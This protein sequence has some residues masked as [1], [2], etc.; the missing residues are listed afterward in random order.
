MRTTIF[1][2]FP[3]VAVLAWRPHLAVALLL[4]GAGLALPAPTRAAGLVVLGAAALLGVPAA[5]R[6]LRPAR[7]PAPSPEDLVVLVL[8]VWHGRADTAALAGLI[9]RAAPDVV[10]LPEAGHDYCAKIVP[11]VAALG[12]DGV[13]TTRAGIPDGWGVTVLTG[14]R[15]D[16]V[17]V[18]V[19]RVMRLPHVEVSGGPLGDRT[20]YAVHTTAPAWLGNVGL[21]RRDLRAAAGWTAAGGIVAGDVNATAD[22]R[23]LR[24][25]GRSAGPAGHGTWPTVLPRWAGI[26]IDHV[27]LPEGVEPTAASVHDVPGTDHR[28]VEVRLRRP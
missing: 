6:L 3:M 7:R 19:G 18:R 14:P 2:R 11:L 9:E 10:V 21:W 17:R 27:L 15:A 22:H 8:N 5:W 24:A 20:L 28:A 12:Y 26:R 25:V 23:L 16:D 4:L 1:D 13:A